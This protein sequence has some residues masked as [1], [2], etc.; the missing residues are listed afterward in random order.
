M[1][2]I[3][4]IQPFKVNQKENGQ[5]CSKSIFRIYVWFEE[6]YESIKHWD[7][8]YL[9]GISHTDF[10]LFPLFPDSYANLS[11]LLHIWNLQEVV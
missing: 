2:I 8:I 4:V 3:C 10:S 7:C 9:W 6:R 1:F 5:G 11:L